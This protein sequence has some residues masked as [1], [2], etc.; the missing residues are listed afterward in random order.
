M[1]ARVK[2]A[3]DV[4]IAFATAPALQ[5]TRRKRRR[6]ALRPGHGYGC[7]FLGGWAAI[8]SSLTSAP[9][10]GRVG[11]I[12]S[13][14]AIIGGCETRSSFHGTSS[15]S[16]S[17]MEKLGMAAQRWALISVEMWP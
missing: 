8:T 14:F 3:H 9:Q 11:T 6:A 13:P 16:I 7:G 1:D 12:S 5:R 4:R 2:P 15:M 17:M 10:P